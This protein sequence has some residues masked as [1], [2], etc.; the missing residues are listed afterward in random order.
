MIFLFSIYFSPVLE[1]LQN[2]IQRAN[3]YIM[4][5]EKKVLLEILSLILNLLRELSSFVYAVGSGSNRF[6]FR[7]GSG[8]RLASEIY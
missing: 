2:K 3:T 1:V 7:Y 4:R 8:S 6:E 5:G